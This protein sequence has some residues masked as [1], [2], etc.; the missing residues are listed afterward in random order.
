MMEDSNVKLFTE[1]YGNAFP[2]MVDLLPY[3]RVDMRDFQCDEQPEAAKITLAVIR[4]SFNLCAL[5]K[6]DNLPAAEAQELLYLFCKNQKKFKSCRESCP[7]CIRNDAFQIRKKLGTGVS[8]EVVRIKSKNRH[9]MRLALKTGTRA[10][11]VVRELLV[12]LAVTRA[13]RDAGLQNFMQTHGYVCGRHA[14]LPTQFVIEEIATLPWIVF[15]PKAANEP[16]S[17]LMINPSLTRDATGAKLVLQVILATFQLAKK[18][19]FN[20]N[21]L[22]IMNVLATQLPHSATFKYD[23]GTTH[24]RLKTKVCAKIIDFGLASVNFE[25]VRYGNTRHPTVYFAQIQE[26]F[27]DLLRFLKSIGLAEPNAEIKTRAYADLRKKPFARYYQKV[28]LNIMQVIQTLI[29]TF[30]PPVNTVSE[31]KDFFN[32]V[33]HPDQTLP[34]K[35]QKKTQHSKKHSTSRLAYHLRKKF[36]EKNISNEQLLR[37]IVLSLNRSFNTQVEIN[38]PGAKVFLET[39]QKHRN[40]KRLQN[41]TTMQRELGNLRSV[42]K[43]TDAARRWQAE[44]PQLVISM[45]SVSAILGV[46]QV[47]ERLTELA[48]RF[49]LCDQVDMFP[50]FAVR[51]FCPAGF[52]GAVCKAACASLQCVGWDRFQTGRAPRLGEGSHGTVTE[53]TL[54]TEQ[55]K[56]V[57]FAMK[58]LREPFTIAA[59]AQLVHEILVGLILTRL[60]VRT[61]CRNFIQTFGY[62]CDRKDRFTTHLLEAVVNKMEF[63]RLVRDHPKEAVGETATGKRLYDKKGRFAYTNPKLSHEAIAEIVAQIFLAVAFANSRVGFCHN[64]L[65]YENVMIQKLPE[66][67]PLVFSISGQI[68]TMST[69]YLVKIIDFGFS[70]IDLPRSGKRLVNQLPAAHFAPQFSEM[71]I[72]VSR[73]CLS[74]IMLDER[75][76]SHSRRVT[77]DPLARLAKKILRAVLGLGFENNVVNRI[78]LSNPERDLYMT[79]EMY[80][81]RQ[82]LLKGKQSFGE[83][84]RKI[85]QAIINTCNAQFKHERRRI[86]VFS[87]QALEKK[88]LR[89]KKALLLEKQKDLQKQALEKK[90]RE[91]QAL[92]SVEEEEEGDAGKEEEE[93]SVEEEEE[94]GDAGKEEEELS[95]EEE[96]EEEEGDA[97]KEQSRRVTKR[98]QRIG[99][100][101][102][103]AMFVVGVRQQ[104]KLRELGQVLEFSMP[105]EVNWKLFTEVVERFNNFAYLET[106]GFEEV[107]TLAALDKTDYHEQTQPLAVKPYRTFRKADVPE[108]AAREKELLDAK[109]QRKDGIKRRRGYTRQEKQDQMRQVDADYQE[110]LARVREQIQNNL[111]P[112]RREARSRYDQQK[113]YL[114]LMDE[115]YLM[116]LPIRQYDVPLNRK[117][118]QNWVTKNTYSNMVRALQ[119]TVVSLQD[120]LMDTSPN[121]AI[122]QLAPQPAEFYKNVYK[123]VPLDAAAAKRLQA[124][125][126]KAVLTMLPAVLAGLT[127]DY[128]A[129]DPDL[130]GADWVDDVKEYLRVFPNARFIFA[131]SPV[132]VSPFDSRAWNL[133]AE[134]ALLVV[135]L[136]T[137]TTLYVLSRLREGPI[138]HLTSRA[139]INMQRFRKQRDLILHAHNLDLQVL[140]DDAMLAYRLGEEGPV[141]LVASQQ[142]LM[143]RLHEAHRRF[144]LLRGY[145]NRD[146]N[147]NDKTGPDRYTRELV[148]GLKE[149][150]DDRMQRDLLRFRELVERLIIKKVISNVDISPD[151]LKAALGTWKPKDLRI[152]FNSVEYL[153]STNDLYRT[154]DNRLR[155]VAESKSAFDAFAQQLRAANLIDSD[156]LTESMIRTALKNLTRM[157]LARALRSTQSLPAEEDD[158][159]LAAQERARLK[160]LLTLVSQTDRDLKVVE[161][162]LPL[163]LG[164]KERVILCQPPPFLVT[165]NKNEAKK[166]PT[167]LDAYRKTWYVPSVCLPVS[168]VNKHRGLSLL[169]YTNKARK[170]VQLV[171]KLS[172]VTRKDV[173]LLA[174][175]DIIP[176]NI[177]LS[178][179]VTTDVQQLQKMFDQVTANGLKVLVLVQAYL[180]QPKRVF[181]FQRCTGDLFRI[182][183]VMHMSFYMGILAHMKNPTAPTSPELRSVLYRFGFGMKILPLPLEKGKCYFI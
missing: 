24:F 161:N 69:R 82:K 49:N 164:P 102:L 115:K 54:V 33:D 1:R 156:N 106:E 170:R 144:Q 67:K 76:R 125:E 126:M 150:F 77:R 40:A 23:V 139:I 140:H 81:L 168:A 118:L 116:P 158:L 167:A 110:R 169:R 97:G 55:G 46:E 145:K 129:E 60:G 59:Q 155:V 177:T 180:N 14:A 130:Q 83:S 107:I 154:L 103:D 75:Y 147:H 112:R 53:K 11:D 52:S 28:A 16:H 62:M 153:A 95:V 64:D 173:G 101:L 146:D 26:P 22:H 17:K 79:T 3:L 65:W 138:R 142:P 63:V 122:G 175:S 73:F 160:K 172:P 29:P 56:A 176:E 12:S 137:P 66:A 149:W 128:F 89:E 47:F 94:E 2:Q 114:Q 109:K 98:K 113:A 121:L 141:A 183:P 143:D 148:A 10:P 100:N 80:R 58:T 45:S 88:Q 136:K 178:G 93:L 8:G 36:K 39:N 32:Y 120:A 85:L 68:Y 105:R 51:L 108:L 37:A 42:V 132:A 99:P 87:K 181:I 44:Y 5:L 20:H 174:N 182:N 71:L 157:D 162:P 117:P 92:L 21:D 134:T 127:Q 104:T 70:S 43:G 7:H 34:G 91:K 41:V 9:N 48:N 152:F 84:N 4:K 30:G 96:E 86:Q 163:K 111:R 123:L 78:M 27:I 151:Q 6:Q 18:V 90:L 133:F 165:E 15:R 166:A 171:N 179:E 38:W 25:N 50:T 119:N 13:A 31:L 19:Q 135:L 35:K 131:N 74:G 124:K 159:K 57:K 61:S 72:D